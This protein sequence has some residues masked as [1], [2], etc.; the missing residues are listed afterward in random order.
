MICCI[1]EKEGLKRHQVIQ[2]S[3]DIYSQKVLPYIL[4]KLLVLCR[5]RGTH[6]GDDDGIRTINDVASSQCMWNKG[7][8]ALGPFIRRID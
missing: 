8:M 7:T 3:N 5:Q 6:H 2:N 4:Y 1:L